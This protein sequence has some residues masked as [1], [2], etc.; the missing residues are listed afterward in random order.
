M[1]TSTGSK[2][3]VPPGDLTFFPRLISERS[4]SSGILVVSHELKFCHS[5]FS[6]IFCFLFSS[7]QVS[8][9]VAL[10][11]VPWH[12]LRRH[13]ILSSSS[14]AAAAAVAAA[15]ASMST[16]FFLSLLHSSVLAARKRGR[17]RMIETLHGRDEVKIEESYIL[18]KLHYFIQRIRD[19]VCL[20]VC[21][22]PS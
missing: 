19:I 16:V 1:S 15:A 17:D 10:L 20:A 13:L 2:T 22:L 4:L 6:P 9:M 12:Y 18:N 3:L 21:L 7:Q 11:P 14:S 5:Y 8:M